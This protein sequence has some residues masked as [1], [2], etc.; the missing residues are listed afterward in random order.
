MFFIASKI[1]Y[2]FLSPFLWVLLCFLIAWRSKNAR[3]KKI[4]TWVGIGMMIFFSNSFITSEFYR[5]WNYEIKSEKEISSYEVG[6]V[7]SGM[8]SFEKET[9]SIHINRGADRIWQALNLYHAKKIKKI[10]ISG[11]NGY[12]TDKGLHEA[13]QFKAVLVQWGIPAEDII[14]ESNS[15]NTAENAIESQKTLK[16]LNLHPTSS[17]KALLITSGLHMRRS[18]AVFNKMNIPVD[19]FPVDGA[20]TI[21][22]DYYF[23]QFIVPDFENFSNWTNLIKEIVGYVVYDVK[24]YI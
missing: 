8:A 10:L 14:T 13:D 2:F 9:K 17:K 6:I 1:F 3:R 19:C 16:K 4:A 7:L 23:Y 15:R 11:D 22:R 24:G 5:L 20:K 18:K 21:E 12:I